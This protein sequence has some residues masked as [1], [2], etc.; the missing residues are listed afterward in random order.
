[1]TTIDL[2]EDLTI[3]AGTTRDITLDHVSGASSVLVGLKIK[4]TAGNF[5]PGIPLIHVK[6]MPSQVI[7]PVSAMANVNGTTDSLVFF[8]M[9]TST[10]TIEVGGNGGGEFQA[11]IFLFGDANGS[12][13]TSE[14]EYMQASAA[15][16]QAAGTGNQNTAL[17]YKSVWGIDLNQSQYD[18]EFDLNQNG[19]V[20]SNELSWVQKNQNVTVKL[21][22]IGDI[23]PPTITVALVNDS[24][25]VGYPGGATDGV[26]NVIP[27]ATD[28]AIRGTITDF[29]NIT[30]ATISG[31]S[32]SVSIFDHTIAE[33]NTA[34]VRNITFGLSR[35]DL[36]ALFGTDVTVGG[37]YTLMLNATDDLGNTYST[38]ITFTFEFDS[39]DPTTPSVDLNAGSDSGTSNTD[40]LTNANT[41]VFDVATEADSLVELFVNGVS[42]GTK[43]DSGSGAVQ[44][45]LTSQF[46]TSG[47]YDI[48]AVAYDA[49]GNMSMD[50]SIL[51]VNIDRAIAAPGITLTN[52]VVEMDASPTRTIDDNGDFAVTV[53]AGSTVSIGGVQV[54]DSD[55]DGKITINDVALAVG[56]N[57]LQVNYSDLAGNSDTTTI[58][59]VRNQTPVIDG[60]SLDGSSLGETTPTNVNNPLTLSGFT[61]DLTAASKDAGESLSYEVLGVDALDENKASLGAS[62][63]VVTVGTGGIV[64]ISDPGGALNFEN[65]VR[66]LTFTVKATD[67][68]GDGFENNPGEG[69]TSA[70]VTFTIDVTDVNEQPTL[71]PTTVAGDIDENST[72]GTVVT[73]SAPLVAFDPDN[74]DGMNLQTLTYS[75]VPDAGAGKLPNIFQ[76]DA[77]TGV[78]SLVASDTLN[79]EVT[80][81]YTLSVVVSDGTLTSQPITVSIS[82]N[83]LNETPEI[84]NAPTAGTIAE[85][86]APGTLVSLNDVFASADPDNADGENLQTLTYQFAAGGDGGGLFAI[87]GTTGAISLAPMQSLNFEQMPNTFDLKVVVVDNGSPV[88]TSSEVTVTVSVTDVNEAPTIDTAPTGG[89]IDENSAP[90]TAVILTGGSFTSSD[91][92]NADGAGL[93]NLTYAF[94]TNGDGGGL[95]V[96]DG[97]TGAISLASGKSLNFE[98][99]PNTFDL[100]V[101]VTDDQTPALSST[102][103]TVHVVI[104]D[105]NEAPVLNTTLYPIT[106]LLLQSMSGGS[107]GLTI[108]VTDPDFGDVLTFSSTGGGTGDS[109]FTVNSDGT[110][111]Y[112]GPVTPGDYTLNINAVDDD[113]TTPLGV[114]GTI[115]I[116][117]LDNLP[118]VVDQT[119]FDVPENLP[120]DDLAFTLTFSEQNGEMDGIKGATLLTNAGGAFKLGTFSNDSIGVLV[121]DSSKLD[122][123]SITPLTFTVR[124]TDNVGSFGDYLITV[125]LT[126]QNDAPVYGGGL[127]FSVDE[128][129]AAAPPT[130]GTPADDTEVSPSLDLSVAFT[131]Q[132]GDMLMYTIDA[133][134]DP[135]G[136]FA[137][138]N[139]KLVVAKPELVDYESDTS[140]TIKVQAF[141]GDVTTSQEIQIDVNQRN[142]LPLPLDGSNMP[143]TATAGVVELGTLNVLFDDLNNMVGME[144]PGG[145]NLFS[146]LNIGADPEGDTILYTQAGNTSFFTLESDGTIKLAQ[147]IAEPMGDFTDYDISFT[148]ADNNPGGSTAS[149]DVGVGLV[150]FTLRVLKNIPPVIA[151]PGGTSTTIAENSA[152][153]TALPTVT[154]SLSDADPMDTVGVPTIAVSAFS[155]AFKLVETGMGT[156]VYTVA[157]ADSTKLNYETIRQTF[158]SGVIPITINVMD[159]RGGAAVPVVINIT[160]TDVNEAP[161]FDAPSFTFNIDEM[162][163]DSTTKVGDA[164]NG[165]AVA[166]TDP[167]SG[168][169]GVTPASD[170]SFSQLK[171]VLSGTGAENFNID[172]NGVITVAAGAMLDAETT[173][174]Y[175]LTVSV[176][177]QDGLG[178]SAATVST[179]TININNVNEAPETSGETPAAIVIDESQLFVGG[180]P[181]YAGEGVYNTRDGYE[182][183]FAIS[184]IVDSLGNPIFSDVDDAISALSFSI[185]GMPTYSAN[186]SFF[187]ISVDTMTGELVVQM[188]HY[189]PS[190]SRLPKTITIQAEDAGG[191]FS[192]TAD[193]TIKFEVENVV[194][195]QI[196]A[197]KA[198]STD[199][200]TNGGVT[201]ADLPGSSNLVLVADNAL[202]NTF[203]YEVWISMNYGIDQ[204]A[205]GRVY[206]D[207][208]SLFNLNLQYDNRYLNVVSSGFEQLANT[209]IAGLQP[210]F[211]T[212][213]DDGYIFNIVGL[214]SSINPNEQTGNGAYFF[215]NM[216]AGDYVRVASLEFTLDQNLM[217]PG[218]TDQLISLYYE[219]PTPLQDPNGGPLKFLLDPTGTGTSLPGTTESQVA[220]VN[221]DQ[222]SENSTSTEVVTDF[223]V[224]NIA[225]TPFGLDL[226]KST[227]DG[228]AMTAQGA[229]GATG[230]VSG[231]LYVQ[232]LDA[233]GGTSQVR[234]VGAD[235]NFG[236]TGNYTPATANKAG[237]ELT[238]A[239]NYGLEQ[240]TSTNIAIRNEG[241]QLS[242]PITLDINGPFFG[243]SI[244][245][246]DSTA[247]D[248]VFDSGDVVSTL[249]ITQTTTIGGVTSM[250]G[251]T[252]SSSGV[253][254]STIQ[255]TEAGVANDLTDDNITI[256]LDLN[257]L[258]FS[259]DALDTVGFAMDLFAAGKIIAT[260]NGGV[261]NP[262]LMGT[263][264]ANGGQPLEEGSGVFLSVVDA[265]TTVDASGEIAALPVSETW[266]SEWDTFWVEVWANTADASGIQSGAVDLKYN[267][268]LF[269]AVKI[270]YASSFDQNRTGL[271]SDGSG[272]ITNLG[273]GT[274][275]D[276]VGKGGFVLLGRVKFQS[277]VNDGLSIEEGLQYGPADLGL[278]ITRG[279]L[280]LADVGLTR[281]A[282]SEAPSVDV[283]AVPYDLDDDGNVSLI[284]L[285]QFVRNVG[286]TSIAV[287]NALSAATDF[288]NDGYTS[289]EDLT[290]LVRNVGV[291]KATAYN[292]IY[293]TTFTQLWVGSGLV[294]SG[295]DTID[296]IFKAAN[297]AWADALGLD[298]P[299]DVRLEVT[300]LGGAQLGEAKLVGL[301]EEGLPVRGVL[302]I[303]DDGAG[304]GWSTDLTNGPSSGQYDLYTVMLHELGH[305]YGFMPQYSAF[306]DQLQTFDGQTIFVGDLYAVEMDS[307][308]EHLDPDLYSSDIMSP[309]LA[310]GVR[311]EISALDVQMILT[312]YA[313][314]DS[315]TTVDSSHAAL[316]EESAFVNNSVIISPVTETTTYDIESAPLTTSFVLGDDVANLADVSGRTGYAVVMPESTRQTLQQSGIAFKTLSNYAAAEHESISE[317]MTDVDSYFDDSTLIE[318]TISDIDST[319][320]G[321]AEEGSVDDLFAEWDEIEMA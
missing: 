3:A 222:V 127:T 206:F 183:R 200:G 302:T 269:S 99:M 105:V 66:F 254:N 178:L 22:L 284:D 83:D 306:G 102:P 19:K 291:S 301:D 28:V 54:T 67:N 141:D 243:A 226:S 234:I 93:Q 177:D 64:T 293:P 285:M 144:L 281:A 118:P 77:T 25:A 289:L 111:N 48:K 195:V 273:S 187:D 294:T 181:N 199:D 155:D 16:I 149:A 150:H 31:D 97:A 190:Q 174:Q 232:I 274:L 235:L 133:S 58:E 115:T 55:K 175:A 119:T 307:R 121:N 6:D 88:E 14:Q 304:F 107:T 13:M 257:R 39:T 71:A 15:Q 311:K 318:S 165:P 125:N 299:L 153:D 128:F 45:S 245:K 12:G 313:A 79:Y 186:D 214:M 204:A 68:K 137:I 192:A 78:I 263:V 209:P 292:L 24:T 258:L 252:V 208:L 220:T 242:S 142:E 9:G 189:L 262:P 295:P 210:T 81:S 231:N 18:Y 73:L 278:E 60:T 277:L 46:V 198:L 193:L 308:G 169:D 249:A 38:P 61:V 108:D 188:F 217:E 36:E 298:E 33:S 57:T 132:D 7:T 297:E 152:N 96:I 182:L 185:V 29:S 84:T 251:F 233:F 113:P 163:P 316:T 41:L 303:D 261:V 123:E 134:T 43:L 154:L 76:I 247:M 63:V 49:A 37:P 151:T 2:V 44:F 109:L 129:V 69:L 271:I 131:D 56:V 89:N 312:A 191:L 309:Y 91:P 167:D 86:S 106:E 272:L 171:F 268:D 70:G 266:L 194:D 253:E 145:K 82:V 176:T 47:S 224:F 259:S 287:D 221:Y 280:E 98:S 267:T 138:V 136:I 11:E 62:G 246:I 90:G 112:T 161:S 248:F 104:N 139:D 32:S 237:A 10:L 94:D 256:S 8:Q 173:S 228:S 264:S 23:D 103:V 218:T 212:N 310:P 250:A 236:D 87:N 201:S 172:S 255:A 50:S 320:A 225:S 170:A 74:S 157:V 130:A 143:L 147:V 315:S 135:N 283:W 80:K 207:G 114:N 26:T 202:D 314:A 239:A 95:F 180:N 305:L 223:L 59:I 51:T 265:P 215:P 211:T 35:N 244:G 20:D 219:D 317:V 230:A 146:I 184:D 276:G 52:N 122:F 1:M 179:V 168:D 288:N 124:V 101:V 85:N 140:Y 21:D 100:K 300:N 92:D 321:D 34:D 216:D 120:N 159:N 162:A 196:R 158:A 238:A 40:N 213:G 296:S 229:T 260:Y 148:Y 241:L 205:P 126:D 110:I 116:R 319:E 65:G 164:L 275:A 17:Y 53:E 166:A 282:T 286:T 42:A 30:A 203:Y 290:Q 117:V 227:L 279:Q 197:V 4:G 5:D 75:I 270:E 240:G 72:A 156:N 27:G 160:V